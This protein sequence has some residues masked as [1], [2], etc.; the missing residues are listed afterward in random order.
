MTSSAPTTRLQR[1]GSMPGAAATHAS[2]SAAASARRTSSATRAGRTI[3]TASTRSR[4]FTEA[5]YKFIIG[6]NRSAKPGQRCRVVCAG[7]PPTTPEGLW[8]M[9]RWAR[10][11]RHEPS[12]SPAKPGELRWYSAGERRQGHRGRRPRAR[13]WSSGEEA[14]DRAS[15]ARSSA[16]EL[17]RQPGPGGRP[18]TRRTLDGA[19]RPELRRAYRD[20]DFSVGIKDDDLQ[21]IPTAWIEAASSAGRRGPAEARHDDGDGAST[22]RPAAAT[23]RVDRLRATAAGSRR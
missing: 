22:S 7:N 13:T 23:R 3:S 10:L 8:V 14:A 20:G 11:A 2:S 9:Q 18:I 5:Q 19:A 17:Q 1:P 16:R 21:V 4:D 6:W 12:A 15:R